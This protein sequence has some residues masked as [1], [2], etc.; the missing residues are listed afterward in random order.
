MYRRLHTL[1]LV[2]S[3]SAFGSASCERSGDNV[4]AARE[5]EMPA[6][7]APSTT[8]TITGPDKEF[9]MQAEKE[10]IQER[11]LGRM[12]QEQCRSVQCRITEKCWSMIIT[13]RC[14]SLSI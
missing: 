10:N 13:M 5:P 12:A 7:S 1:I 6:P 11:V 9:V 14:K 4:Q 2:L 3:L 8:N